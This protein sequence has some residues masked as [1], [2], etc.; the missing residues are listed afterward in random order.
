MESLQQVALVCTTFRENTLP[1]HLSLV[2]QKLTTCGFRVVIASSGLSGE[3][4]VRQPALRQGPDPPVDPHA[5]STSGSFPV[6]RSWTTPLGLKRIWHDHRTL[7]KLSQQIH[8]ALIISDG[9]YGCWHSTI[10]SVFISHQVEICVPRNRGFM[11]WILNKL[12]RFYIRQYSECWIPDF[13][14]HKGLAGNLSHPAKLPQNAHYIGIL[15]HFSPLLKPGIDM[16]M[17]RFD[18][19]VMLSASEIQQNNP[20]EMIMLQLL[21]LDLQVAIIRATPASDEALVL[22]ERIHLFSRLET[23]QMFELMMQSRLIICRPCY[24][25]IMDVVT[26][27]K[28]AILIPTP[29]QPEQEYLARYLMEKKI[30]FSAAE[31]EFD[32]VYSLEMSINFPGMVI[33]NDYRDM[34]ERIRGLLAS[35]A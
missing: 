23:T 15:S 32:L 28:K 12:N 31:S 1:S 25:D 21:N 4:F 26:L 2:I 29:G 14:S 10:K 7:K 5:S 13:E 11:K 8:P 34:T 16:L 30:M 6:G 17:P 20:E 33:R 9:R 24:S 19:L 18:L 27:G 3:L 22:D 35:S